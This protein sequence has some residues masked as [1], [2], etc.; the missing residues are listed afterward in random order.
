MGTINYVPMSATPWG[1]FA[2]H[3]AP[4]FGMVYFLMNMTNP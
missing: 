4:T 1:G 3:L 2:P